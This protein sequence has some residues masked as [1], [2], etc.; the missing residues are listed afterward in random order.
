MKIQIPGNAFVKLPDSFLKQVPVYKGRLCYCFHKQG[1]PAL[2][3]YLLPA[4]HLPT[5]FPSSGHS[6]KNRFLH[7]RTDTV[8]PSTLPADPED[9]L[10][11]GPYF[12]LPE[13]VYYYKA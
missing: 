9:R 2:F 7:T 4:T 5:F 10:L 11:T 6:L 12:Y 13:S 8:F 3:L 1:R